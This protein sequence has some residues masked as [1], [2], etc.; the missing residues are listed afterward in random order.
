MDENLEI[1]LTADVRQANK[2]VNNFKNTLNG[3]NSQVLSV[4]QNFKRLSRTNV[5]TNNITSSFKKMSVPINTFRDSLAYLFPQLSK[6]VT[7]VQELSNLEKIN[8]G[9]KIVGSD[10]VQEEV[11]KLLS[12]TKT[13]QTTML[14]FK[15]YYDS[16]F[17][18]FSKRDG[19]AVNKSPEDI[20]VPKTSEYKPPKYNRRST[21]NI[22]TKPLNGDGKKPKAAS[23]KGLQAKLEHI[24]TDSSYQYIEETDTEI[25][26]GFRHAPDDNIKLFEELYP[27]KISR[28]GM[29]PH[30][31]QIFQAM[32]D[33]PDKEFGSILSTLDT[34][35]ILYRN[36]VIVENISKS[37][38]VMKDLM[39][40]TKA[41]SLYLVFG[42]G[43][44]DV[45]RPLTRV[46]IETLWRM[47]VEEMKFQ[48]GKTVE[49][50]HRLLMLLDE[51]PA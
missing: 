27:D 18:Y 25:V 35:L 20:K 51:F 40:S 38:F 49:H 30:V 47:N 17:D 19:T 4:K 29:H 26:S 16:W 44:I 28:Y 36:P 46:I 50:Q 5:N 23:L 32:I 1:V 41:I 34:A 21:A 2:S 15:K 31:R 43:E 8:L 39:D 48:G 24:I 3:L 12:S 9:T 45:V 14:F 37:D 11:Q 22:N 7:S 10:V 42:P 13:Y 33:K 6:L